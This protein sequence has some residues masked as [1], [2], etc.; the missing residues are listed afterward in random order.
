MLWLD[1]IQIRLTAI[2]LLGQAAMAMEAPVSL[3]T[4][5]R[6]FLTNTRGGGHHHSWLFPLCIISYVKGK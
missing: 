6:V 3:D 2:Q 1:L 4:W 5:Y